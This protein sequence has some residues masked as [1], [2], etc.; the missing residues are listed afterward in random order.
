VAIVKLI[1][2]RSVDIRALDKPFLVKLLTR[3]KMKAFNEASR[4]DFDN[5][6]RAIDIRKM[7]CGL[8]T[9]EVSEVYYDN[10]VMIVDLTSYIKPGMETKIERLLRVADQS[11]K[12][13]EERFSKKE[14]MDRIIT[15]L[16][17][18]N[19]AL[20]YSLGDALALAL[21]PE[22]IKAEEERLREGADIAPSMPVEPE[23]APPQ[24]G[25]T[26]DPLESAIEGKI[27]SMEK[28]A[29]KK[30]KTAKK[31]K[32]KKK[33]VE[34][35]TVPEEMPVEEHVEPA[36]ETAKEPVP[37]TVPEESPAEVAPETVPEPAQEETAPPPV[38]EPASTSGLGDLMARLRGID[39]GSPGQ[40]A[41]SEQEGAPPE[42]HVEPVPETV[43][44]TQPEE[45]A[46]PAPETVEET[47]PEEH[48]EPVPETV[49]E[50]QP[51]EHVEPAPETVE[52]TLPE[53]HA[54]PEVLVPEPP[55]E[56]APVE[57]VQAEEP[58]EETPE[59]EHHEAA[60]ETAEA[61]AG[62]SSLELIMKRL[63][64][65]TVAAPEPPKEEEPSDAQARESLHDAVADGTISDEDTEIAAPVEDDP[66]KKKKK[67]KRKKGGKKSKKK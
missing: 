16:F 32:K 3:L 49:E 9:Q 47:P 38:P 36:P 24:A 51:E 20:G 1:D 67:R 26:Y 2:P 34:P 42:E 8:F 13:H 44:E 15:K 27:A 35:E 53:E 56:E 58:S 33:A 6:V 22:E 43:E 66:D 17:I 62:A 46:E 41:G 11:P 48:V 23:T 64:S 5:L 37:E 54:E 19:V 31:K 10:D 63:R 29:K 21:N 52:E 40:E 12:I 14:R 7:F 4:R 18:T 59:A 55:V 50:T 57:P 30:K 61:E 25:E 28:A 60:G 65:S 45:Q 39:I